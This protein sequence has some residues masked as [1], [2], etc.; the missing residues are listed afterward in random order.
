MLRSCFKFAGSVK[1]CRVSKILMQVRITDYHGFLREAIGMFV[2]M[3]TRL[4]YTSCL[5]QQIAIFRVE[6]L[7]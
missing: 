5:E 6:A 1:I 2:A 3:L 4:N 7:S